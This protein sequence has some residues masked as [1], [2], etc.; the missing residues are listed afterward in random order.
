MSLAETVKTDRERSGVSS[1]WIGAVL[2]AST[3]VSFSVEAA[4]I[5]QQSTV[6]AQSSIGAAIKGMQH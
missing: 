4:S 2:D 3:A 6:P 1:S 5:M